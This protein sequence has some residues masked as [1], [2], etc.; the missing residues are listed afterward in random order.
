VC[1]FYVDTYVV[2]ARIGWWMEHRHPPPTS[3]IRRLD[4]AWHRF[5]INNQI[6]GLHFG[7]Y[8]SAA[9]LFVFIMTATMRNAPESRPKIFGVV[10]L[11]AQRNL[12]L[13]LTNNKRGD[14]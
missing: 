7:F 13:Q 1:F 11:I 8:V 4:T 12:L 5:M 3:K 2:G 14:F 9:S 10:Q 6:K